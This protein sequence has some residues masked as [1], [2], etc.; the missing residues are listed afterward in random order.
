MRASHAPF[1]VQ[2]QTGIIDRVTNRG[3]RRDGH[4]LATA[5]FQIEYVLAAGTGFGR[6]RR[7]MVRRFTAVGAV[8][9][10]DPLSMP[11]NTAAA[12]L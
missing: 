5:D 11:E 6:L 3:D 4:R 9:I 12:A 2:P 8:E 7:Q 10:A 1:G